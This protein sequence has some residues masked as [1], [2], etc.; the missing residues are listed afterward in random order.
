[1]YTNILKFAFSGRIYP[2]VRG[3]PATGWGNS[4]RLGDATSLNTTSNLSLRKLGNE[5]LAP[6]KYCENWVGL[7]PAFVKKMQREFLPPLDFRPM[8]FH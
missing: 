2:M 1:M 6:T 8:H 7:G 3:N 5:M 4:G